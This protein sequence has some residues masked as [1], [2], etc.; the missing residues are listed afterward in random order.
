MSELLSYEMREIPRSF[1]KS[2]LGLSLGVHGADAQ[3]LGFY[4]LANPYLDSEGSYA[5]PLKAMAQHTGIRTRRVKKLLQTLR[6]FGFCC[7]D[8]EKEWVSVPLVA[9]IY[10]QLF[11]RAVDDKLVTQPVS[12]EFPLYEYKE[13]VDGTLLQN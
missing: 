3:K 12:D 1:F 9:V 11:R 10:A 6:A 4:L 7:Y 2:V 5:L 8:F 13:S